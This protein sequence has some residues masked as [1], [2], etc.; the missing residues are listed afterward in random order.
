MGNLKT[1]EVVKTI[2]NIIQRTS[3][4]LRFAERQD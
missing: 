3:K 4:N 2:R 1:E